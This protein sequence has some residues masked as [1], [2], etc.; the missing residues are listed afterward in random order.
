LRVGLFFI[1]LTEKGWTTYF[2]I[3]TNH[4]TVHFK[5]GYSDTARET[6][7]Y[8]ESIYTRLTSS[9]NV[10]FP[11]RTH[12]ILN[13]D[14][15]FVNAFATGTPLNIIEI[16]LNPPLNAF[17]LAHM[18][19]KWLYNIL[20]HEMVHNI[21]L[22]RRDHAFGLLSKI[23]GRALNSLGFP[24]D[25]WV[26]EGLAVYFESKFPKNPWRGRL[27]EPYFKA[28]VYFQSLSGEFPKFNR[29][30]NEP[31]IWLGSSA[32]YIYGALFFEYL[33]NTYGPETVMNY[34]KINTGWFLFFKE[35]P[36]I[37]VFKKRPRDLWEE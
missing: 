23:F 29:V 28:L 2:F 12:I 21:H 37:Q 4:F 14:N 27:G 36:F 35:L 5:A 10:R 22:N 1:I 15:R 13:P 32:Y 25:L 19:N 8:A 11:E 6:A 33:A 20:L 9:F 18:G 3:K 30:N 34:L 26:I 17:S 31:G 7:D 16:Y 24:Q